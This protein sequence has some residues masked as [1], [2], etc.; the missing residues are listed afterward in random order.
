MA[1]F[2][3]ACVALFVGVSLTP[4]EESAPSQRID[5]L[6]AELG[7]P[8]FHTRQAAAQALDHIG[9]PAL[10]A[11]REAVRTTADAEVRQRAETLVAKI[12]LRAE[13]EDAIAPS[14]VTL[15]AGARKLREILS[16]CTKQTHAQFHLTDPAQADQIIKI[17][18][19]TDQPFWSALGTICQAAHLEIGLAADRNA[20]PQSARLRN[21]VDAVA[22]DLQRNTEQRIALIRQLHEHTIARQKAAA[23]PQAVRAR[24]EAIAKIKEAMAQNIRQLTALRRNPT[25][26][27][28]AQHQTPTHDPNGIVLQPQSAAPL[29]SCVQG[30]IRIVARPFPATSQPAVAADI[31]PVLLELQ[32]EPQLDWQR[33]QRVTVAK[34]TGSDGQELTVKPA[35]APQVQVHRVGDGNIVI[36]ANGGVNLMPNHRPPNG[37]PQAFRPTAM[38]QIVEIRKDNGK[39]VTRLSRLEGTIHGTIRTKPEAIATIETLTPGK[40]VQVQGRNDSEMTATLTPS[41]DGK[42]FTLHLLLHYDPMLI[43]P[44]GEASHP[45]NPNIRLR[46]GAIGVAQAVTVTNGGPMNTRAFDLADANGN[47]Y[48]LNITQISNRMIVT[49]GKQSFVRSVQLIVTPTKAE[50]GPPTQLTFRGTMQRDVEIPFTLRNV[51]LLPHP[52]PLVKDPSP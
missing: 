20:S 31:L 30:G 51:P 28:P 22:A 45:I 34:V 6:I 33:I 41:A 21:P 12:G 35:D 37:A 2:T 9:R 50:C 36:D 4:A 26:S 3:A 46:G 13:N 42:P 1:R 23:N 27:A 49:N 38:Q 18:E 10:S 17:P 19:I 52:A 15:A 11:L 48:A 40:T 5:L 14:R 32:T 47:S 24:D 7:S 16:E 44:V 25:Q 29:P 8:D 43:T 39:D